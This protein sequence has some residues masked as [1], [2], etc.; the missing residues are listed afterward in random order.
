MLLKLG[1]IRLNLS[2]ARS[3]RRNGR[4]L[5]S[6]LLLAQR[7]T[8]C[9]STLPSFFIA[10]WYERSPSVAIFSGDPWRFSAFFMKVSAAALSRV[11]VM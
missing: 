10:A 2:I 7:L 5:F 9:C 3:R 11:L 1:N 6:T 8:S 4:W